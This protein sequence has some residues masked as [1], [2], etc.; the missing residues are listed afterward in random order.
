MA[1]KARQSSKSARGEAAVGAGGADLGEE[2]V[3]VE[4]AGAGGEQDVLAEHV[5]RAGAARLA[6]EVVVAHGVERGA[7][8]EHLEAVGGHEH[9]AGGGVVAVVGAADALDEALD[10]LRRAD[11]DHEVDVAPVDAEVERAGGDDGAQRARPPSPPRPSGAA[12]RESEPWCSAIGRASSFSAQSVLEEELGLGAGVDEDER[13][14]WR[15]GSGP[16]PRGRRSA[17]SARP[18]AAAPRSAR[19]RMSG[20]G[21]GSASRTRAPSPRQ[22]ASAGGSS[23]VAERPTRRRRGREGLQPGEAEHELVAA[24]AFGERV[25]L[26]DDDPRE[27]GED[28][29]RLLV[30]EHQREGLGRGQQDVRRVDALA[31]ALRPRR[32]RRCGP[33]R[34]RRGPSRRAGAARLR[35]MSAASAFSG[36]T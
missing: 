32:C 3:G 14:A 25:D 15:R 30:G 1:Q 33:R 22:A 36:E 10:V 35:R 21:P 31:G 20:S 27:A 11:L 28:A 16:S 8:F 4:R 2:R 23:T 24:L 26:V 34:G 5:E 13:G 6:V 18:R 9:G 19:M 12:S 29:R 17:R 7:A